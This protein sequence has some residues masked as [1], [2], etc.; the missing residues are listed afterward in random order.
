MADDSDYYNSAFNS[1]RYKSVQL[2]G[3]AEAQY[4]DGS[5]AYAN[6]IK[7][8]ISFYHVPTGKSVFFKAFITAFNETYASNWS[9]EDVYGRADP[10]YLFKNTTREITLAFEIPAA[11][12]SEAYENLGKISLLAKFLYPGYG[13]LQGAQ[14]IT[15][16]PLIRV[17]VMNLLKT[18]SGDTMPRLP[19]VLETSQEMYMDYVSTESAG[20]GLLGVIKNLVI[21]HNLHENGVLEKA[22]NTILPKMIDVNLSFGALHEHAMGWDSQGRFG[23]PAGASEGQG[24]NTFPYGVTLN[25]PAAAAAITNPQ[26]ISAIELDMKKQ[27]KY[28]QAR[29]DEASA[30]YRG[31]LE[32]TWA[33]NR[34]IRLIWLVKM[35]ITTKNWRQG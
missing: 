16:S 7:M 31:G 14:T 21:N 29:T 3:G 34:A 12:E 9:S 26:D 19:G 11:T 28:M 24:S 13:D 25:D 15:Q 22:R 27:D 10:I 20:T 4:A 6:I 5:D 33:I 35:V 1:Q 23:A 8:V 17:K 2:A 32:N 18:T 30:R